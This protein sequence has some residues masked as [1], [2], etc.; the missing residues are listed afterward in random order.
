MLAPNVLRMV[1]PRDRLEYAKG[2]G[3]GLKIS[4]WVIILGLALRGE[5]HSLY[6]I[7]MTQLLS[8]SPEV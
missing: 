8:F 1:K 7:R 4:D 6:K 5:L 2:V 3:A